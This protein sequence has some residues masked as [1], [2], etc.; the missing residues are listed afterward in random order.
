VDWETL[1]HNRKLK[2]ENRKTENLKAV[3]GLLIATRNKNKT[4]EITQML[5]PL[6]TVRDLSAL[7]N[8][9]EIEETG[10]TFQENAALKALAISKLTKD[11]VLADDSGLEVD[12]LNGAPGVYSARYAGKNATDAENRQLL[13]H[14]LA[15]LSVSES[16]GRFRCSMAVARKGE[17]L[18]VFDGTVEGKVILEERGLNGFG[19][20]PIFVPEGLN[21]TFG[22]L[23][24]ATKDS[25][26]HRGKALR[27]VVEFLR[28]KL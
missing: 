10:A 4:R 3:P 11:L 14:N 9:P 7:P 15:A 8:T 26:S 16:P 19:Y 13:I 22:E 20:D 18:G 23:P 12:A 1:S 2:T 6:W 27:K 21:E 5:G 28:P 17:L 24:S 25:M